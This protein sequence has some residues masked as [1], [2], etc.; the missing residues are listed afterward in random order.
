M[1]VSPLHLERHMEV[2]VQLEAVAGSSEAYVDARL[3]RLAAC[4][5][6]RLEASAKA[7]RRRPY[8]RRIFA[9]RAS[10]VDEVG[11]D[12][13]GLHL[14]PTCCAA[15]SPSPTRT[16]VSHAPCALCR[17]SLSMAC[18]G[19][20][21]AWSQASAGPLQVAPNCPKA[22]QGMAWVPGTLRQGTRTAAGPTACRSWRPSSACALLPRLTS[23]PSWPGVRLPGWGWP[24]EHAEPRHAW[25]SV[26]QGRGVG[27]AAAA[28]LCVRWQ[29]GRA[30][31]QNSATAHACVR[32]L[33]HL[34]NAKRVQQACWTGIAALPY[35]VQAALGGS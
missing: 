11:W 16:G 17:W 1:Q 13:G 28:A 27:A 24:A 32:L 7:R 4:A 34:W 19:C 2:C 18:R 6:Q 29:H 5:E 10:Q 14:G 20:K 33:V 30:R 31:T 9:A 3:T 23:T 22:K 35:C 21:A 26:L 8:S 12:V 15:P 25:C